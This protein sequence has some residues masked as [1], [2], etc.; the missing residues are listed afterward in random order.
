MFD[1]FRINAKDIS[2]N[3]KTRRFTF[4]C[5]SFFPVGQSMP[6]IIEVF[7][8]KT[9]N[10]ARYQYSSRRVI[11]GYQIAHWTYLPASGCENA[12]KTASLIVFNT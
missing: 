8:E 1:N 3:V 11:N 12:A 6:H 4:D 5:S 9:G 7:N 2:Y 10:F